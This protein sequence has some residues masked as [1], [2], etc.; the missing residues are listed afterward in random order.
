V[1]QEEGG[2]LVGHC[3][4]AA[5]PEPPG[6]LPRRADVQALNRQEGARPDEGAHAR[7]QL[8]PAEGVPG[9]ASHGRATCSCTPAT[10]LRSPVCRYPPFP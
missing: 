8:Q 9:R 5:G 6:P 10:N 1:L 7:Q 4:E 3:E 2:K